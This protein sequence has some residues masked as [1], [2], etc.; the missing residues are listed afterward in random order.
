MSY[1][2]KNREAILAHK[3]EYYA[4]NAEYRKLYQKYYRLK[5]K[6]AAIK[7]LAA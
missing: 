6:M 1:Y 7:D 2:Q 5:K 3:K 4:N